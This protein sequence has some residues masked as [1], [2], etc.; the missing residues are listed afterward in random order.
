[1]NDRF[2]VHRIYC[3]EA[4]NVFTFASEAKSILCVRPETRALNPEAL[5]QF[6]G[7]GA[8]FDDRTLFQGISLLPAGSSWNIGDPSAISK[9]RYFRPDTWAEQP[10]LDASTFYTTLRHT[11]SNIP[12]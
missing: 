10:A 1:M 8:V 9:H 7:F 5:G 4:Q 3:H 6:L 2:G 11:F 12:I